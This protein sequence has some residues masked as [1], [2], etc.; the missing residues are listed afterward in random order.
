VNLIAGAR[1]IEINTAFPRDKTFM[2]KSAIKSIYTTHDLSRL[3]H[4]NPRSVI[5]WIEQDLLQSFRTPG[6]HRRV[7]HEDLIA[8]L[9]K[10]KMPIPAELMSGTFSVLVVESE[11]GVSKLIQADSQTSYNVSNATDGINA[12]IALGRNRPDL[13]ILDLGIAGVD[14]LEICRKIKADPTNHTAVLAISRE[15][16]LAD[17]ARAAGADAFLAK[18]MESDALLSQMHKLLQVM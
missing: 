8:F 1:G 7:R 17:S 3:L 13:I 15:S 12:L 2:E 9:R 11:D 6:G 14:G 18:P 4:V 16:N 5:N 10:H